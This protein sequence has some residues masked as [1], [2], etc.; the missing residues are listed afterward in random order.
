LHLHHGH[1]GC[2]KYITAALCAFTISPEVDGTFSRCLC[3]S[4]SHTFATKHN[5]PLRRG[6]EINANAIS[7]DRISPSLPSRAKSNPAPLESAIASA[8][9]ARR[10]AYDCFGFTAGRLSASN[11]SELDTLGFDQPET[12]CI[13]K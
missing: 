2:G 13:L 11:I 7:L 5:Q 3:L 8:Y 6:D 9:P 1:H 10:R 4:A 12:K